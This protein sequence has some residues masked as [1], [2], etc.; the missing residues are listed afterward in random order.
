MR[1]R[2][3]IVHV[4]ESRHVPRR[5]REPILGGVTPQVQLDAGMRGLT[6]P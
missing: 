2:T 5:I 4:D 6:A 1:Y 3:V